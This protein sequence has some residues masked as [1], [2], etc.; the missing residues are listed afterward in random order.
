[1]S[2]NAELKKKLDIERQVLDGATRM[3]AVLRATP[4]PD[5]SQCQ[6]LEQETDSARKRMALIEKELQM[7]PDEEVRVFEG[8]KP[9]FPG[10]GMGPCYCWGWTR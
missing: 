3:L 10:R 7:A 5:A 9:G 8:R 4:N 2:S 6:R 1:L